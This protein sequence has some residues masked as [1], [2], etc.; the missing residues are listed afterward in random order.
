MEILKFKT[1]IQSSE[2]LQKVTPLLNQEE[3]IHQWKL[4]TS[5]E[6]HL[7]NISGTE[8]DPLRVINLLEQAGFQAA[9]IQAFGTGG[10][11]L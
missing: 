11:G 7:L 8:P 3:S 5:H 6:D 2:G 10:A 1:N 4:D 9:F